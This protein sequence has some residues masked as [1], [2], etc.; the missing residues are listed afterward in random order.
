MVASLIYRDGG[1]VD[2]VADE[3]RTSE[4]GEGVEQLVHLQGCQRAQ[5]MATGEA[6]TIVYAT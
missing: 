4:Q 3:E 6:L 5:E 1:L 2:D